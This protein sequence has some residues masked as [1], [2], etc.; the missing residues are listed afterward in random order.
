MTEQFRD[1]VIQFLRRT[2]ASLVEDPEL[3]HTLDDDQLLQAAG[4]DS[5]RIMNLLVR[6]ETEYEIMFDDDELLLEN[7][8]SIHVIADRISQKAGI[9]L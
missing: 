8:E 5:I 7:F 1:E 3:E 9:R 4:M 6:I 2:I